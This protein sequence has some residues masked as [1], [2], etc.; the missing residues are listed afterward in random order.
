VVVHRR[1]LVVDTS[2]HRPSPL[3]WGSW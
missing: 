3:L 1:G 2:G